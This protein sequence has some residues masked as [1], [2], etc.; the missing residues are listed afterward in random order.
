LII[1]LEELA[2]LVIQDINYFQVLAVIMIMMMVTL[3]SQFGVIGGW[4]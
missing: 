1:R 2:H 3:L 4:Y